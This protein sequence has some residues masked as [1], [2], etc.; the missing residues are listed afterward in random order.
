M[1]D[2]DS[3]IDTLDD[4]VQQRLRQ[5]ITVIHEIVPTATASISYGVP[6]FREGKFVIHCAGYP[7]H[8][9]LYPGAA[10]VRE[11]SSKLQGYKT[12]KGTVQFQNNEPLPLDL[13]RSITVWCYEQ[14]Q[15][16]KT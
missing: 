5:I 12:S 11:F 4:T 10:A 1:N 7:H 2:I 15:S 9:A 13:I 16:T 6:T 8:T 14:H 3:Y